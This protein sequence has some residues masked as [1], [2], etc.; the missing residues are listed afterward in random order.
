MQRGQGKK[1]RDNGRPKTK[2]DL[3]PQRERFVTRKK[4]WGAL[5]LRCR[6]KRSVYEEN[7]SSDP[8]REK[9]AAGAGNGW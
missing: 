5:T 9:L 2:P 7:K 3:H 6:R 1:E 4:C 8:G